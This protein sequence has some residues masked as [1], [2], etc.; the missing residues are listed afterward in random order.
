MLLNSTALIINLTSMDKTIKPPQTTAQ[1][2]EPAPLERL[3]HKLDMTNFDM[4]EGFLFIRLLVSDREMSLYVY[5]GRHDACS[6]T[7][8]IPHINH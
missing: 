5:T 3:Q 2:V 8:G 7:H 1:Q 6:L 4:K